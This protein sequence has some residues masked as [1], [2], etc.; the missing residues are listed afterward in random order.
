MRRFPRAVQAYIVV[1]IASGGGV[2]WLWCQ[3]PLGS[4]DLVL[5]AALALP[6]IVARMRPL[7]LVYSH[8]RINLTGG[9]LLM[10]VFL[11]SPSAA[12]LLAA[13]I[14]LLS[15]LALRLTPWNILFTTAVNVL[16]V[17]FA[18]A[19]YHDI[20]E[21]NTLP[22]DSPI[23]L[24]ALLLSASGFWIVNSAMVTV[25]VAARNGEMVWRAY[26]NNWREVY[27]QCILL[28]LLAVLGAAVWHQG[29]AYALLLLLPAIAIYQLLSITRLKQEQVINAIQIIAEVL[30]RRNPFTFQHSQRVAEH[31]TKIARELGMRQSDIEVLRR[32]ALIHDI[33]K[34]GVDDPSAELLSCRGNLTD[35]QFYSLKQHAQMGA[36]IAREIPAFEEAEQP[37]R[38]HHDWYD[39]SRVSKAHA[40]EE[41]P[42]GARILAVADSYDCLCMA[43]GE[44]TLAYD[45]I[46]VEQLS[47]MGGRR[48]DPALLAIFLRILESQQARQPIGARVAQSPRQA[49]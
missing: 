15:G 29:P 35:Y 36:L 1:A 7:P 41:I 46:A 25:L 32:A 45:P 11:A 43:N 4:T 38:Y 13:L 24:L 47:I 33:G 10:A 19:L 44:A 9:I 22:L 12:G 31:A 39:G 49:S 14:A 5:I 8:L 28:T 30:D 48:L 21:P 42:V 23:N 40:G 2:L 16:S 3:E 27:L 37:I 6:G 18:G 34:M 20:V 26:V 17:G